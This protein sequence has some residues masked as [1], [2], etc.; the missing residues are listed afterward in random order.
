[1]KENVADKMT[2]RSIITHGKE[3]SA[4]GK[5]KWAIKLMH[6]VTFMFLRILRVKL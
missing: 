4:H 5:L 3:A 1:M 6:F 2:L